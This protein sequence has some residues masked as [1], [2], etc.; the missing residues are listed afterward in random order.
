MARGLSHVPIIIYACG[1]HNERT[2]KRR[3]VS[4]ETY[5]KLPKKR[6]PT[7]L[8]NFIAIRICRTVSS[9]VGKFHCFLRFFNTLAVV[10]YE[11]FLWLFHMLTISAMLPLQSTT[12]FLVPKNYNTILC[13]CRAHYPKAC[14]RY[15]EPGR[16]LCFYTVQQQ[17]Q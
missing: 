13:R 3:Y 9:I 5:S 17:P 8:K 1:E 6:M 14:H 11:T 7:F 15:K 16:N 12:I 2:K 4:R 10:L